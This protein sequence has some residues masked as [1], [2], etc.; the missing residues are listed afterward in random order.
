M[1]LYYLCNRPLRSLTSKDNLLFRRSIFRKNDFVTEI[2][3]GFGSF[4]F[5]FSYN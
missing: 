4:A 1:L 2:A 5:E 3:D